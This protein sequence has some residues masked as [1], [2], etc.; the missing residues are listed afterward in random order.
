MGESGGLQFPA[1]D[2]S[3]TFI[4][5]TMTVVH[6]QMPSS[7]NLSLDDSH[8]YHLPERPLRLN[9]EQDYEIHSDYIFGAKFHL[10]RNFNLPC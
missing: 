1:E 5:L 7:S 8:M 10:S 2:A 3:T 6:D 4:Q 9:D